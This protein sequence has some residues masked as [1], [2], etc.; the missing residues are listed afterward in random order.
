MTK[1]N[2]GSIIIHKYKVVKQIGVTYEMK[3]LI[4]ILLTLNMFVIFT[5]CSQERKTDTPKVQNENT[6][7]MRDEFKKTSELMDELN[8]KSDSNVRPEDK[9]NDSKSDNEPE[10]NADNKSEE[11]TN[12]DRDIIPS[13]RVSLDTTGD[14]KGLR[15]ERDS[16]KNDAIGYE[17]E[18]NKANKASSLTGGEEPVKLAVAT[19]NAYKNGD[20]NAYSKLYHPS[21]KGMTLTNDSA[22]T[23]VAYKVLEYTELGGNELKQLNKGLENAAKLSGSGKKVVATEFCRITLEVYKF[24]PTP[25]IYDKYPDYSA[26]PQYLRVGIYKADGEYYVYTT[27]TV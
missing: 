15:L 12:T 25:S 10:N 18:H 7:N 6:V 13:G 5:G 22:K 21:F 27:L 23:F 19:F 11:K 14:Y 17:I 8:D 26:D 16:D 20:S 4:T 9:N 24:E 1:Y 3:R 2:I